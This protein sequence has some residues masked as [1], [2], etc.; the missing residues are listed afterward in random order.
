MIVRLLD[1]VIGGLL[2]GGIFAL[3][4]VGFGLQYGV[5]RVLNIAHGEFIMLGAFC[6]WTL[7]TKAGVTPLISMAFCAPFFFVVGFII[8]R[9]LYKPL[10]SSAESAGAFEG[11][12]ML[13]SFGLMF[14][15]QNIALLIWGAPVKGYTYLAYP[16]NIFGALFSANRIVTLIASVVLGGAFYVFLLRTRTGKAI[17]ASAQD[18]DAAGLMGVR[19]NTVLAICFGFG[20]M[21][22]ALGGLLLSMTSIML[23]PVM[24]MQYTLIAIIVVVL[25]GLGNIKGSFVGGF[26][27]GLV[28]YVVSSLQPGLSMVAYYVI[29]LLLL[30]IRPTG[31]FAR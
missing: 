7:F 16:V 29:F 18:P 30:L 4:A 27:L 12:S 19:I 5:T 9:I 25:G 3:I 24:G 14:V 22:A 1:I 2:T 20:A 17:R 23:S 31:L 6:A 26:I 10:R 28:G 21:M 15:V 11:N 8:Y 13:A